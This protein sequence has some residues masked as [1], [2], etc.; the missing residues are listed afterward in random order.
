MKR[1]VR[2]TKGCSIAWKRE[3]GM[4]IPVSRVIL[5]IYLAK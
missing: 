4:E 2:Q 1:G 5:F 3:V